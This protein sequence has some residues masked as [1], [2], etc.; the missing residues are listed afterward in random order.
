MAVPD[1]YDKSWEAS[2]A[3]VKCMSN[4]IK[5]GYLVYPKVLHYEKYWPKV[6]LCYRYQ[7]RVFYDPNKE[8]LQKYLPFKIYRMYH[9]LYA[10]HL[11]KAAKVIPLPPKP[12]VKYG[13]PP[14]PLHM[15]VP[16]PPPKS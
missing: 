13:P 2:S 3:D 14:P 6:V 12:I 16:P 1:E 7:G 5:L 4:C 15:A 9:A 10:M 8:F 11:K